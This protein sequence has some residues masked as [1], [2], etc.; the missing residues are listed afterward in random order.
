MKC[1]FID[2]CAVESDCDDESD[3]NLGRHRR[4]RRK[5]VI[6]SDEDDGEEMTK[7]D[8]DFVVDDH[9]SPTADSPRVRVSRK[10]RKV[11][12]DDIELIKE[13]VGLRRTKH[14]GKK[15]KL[16]VWKDED[17]C[18]ACSDDEGFVVEDDSDDDLGSGSCRSGRGGAADGSD[19]EQEEDG[20]RQELTCANMVSDALRFRE[21]NTI[22][23]TC[24]AEVL[25]KMH[26]SDQ[27]V[28]SGEVMR[29]G[30]PELLFDEFTARCSGGTRMTADVFRNLKISAAGVGGA[31]KSVRKPAA[32]KPRPAVKGKAG[33][34]NSCS[35]S[36]AVQAETQPV[37]VSNP[38]TGICKGD[39]FYSE[40]MYSDPSAAL[41]AC[42]GHG[43]SGT[44]T[45]CEQL[46]NRGDA[47]QVQ[48]QDKREQP[49]QVQVQDKREEPVQVQVPEK[50][51]EPV[52][53]QVH[54]VSGSNP[55]SGRNVENRVSAPHASSPRQYKEQVVPKIKLA[56]I[57]LPLSASAKVAASGVAPRPGG[58]AVK[59]QKIRP[60]EYGLIMRKDGTCF[61]R[62]EDGTVEERGRL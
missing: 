60:P 27:W 42:W 45:Q 31:G 55:G 13:N 35:S 2:D 62:H 7:E 18:D 16:C 9:L 5:R 36:G 58:K 44:P 34:V 12:R 61:Y 51:G 52:Q 6:Q 32:P 50:R 14:K 19:E 40:D 38:L 30:I 59:A 56:S 1:R 11:T 33:A 37:P 41:T 20:Q 8:L 43:D 26:A 57:F 28:L 25:E 49:V 22:K 24:L 21:Q 3:E 46:N 23:S 10:E 54:V 53:V 47:V 15:E 48:V 17:E 39:D 4:R 29:N